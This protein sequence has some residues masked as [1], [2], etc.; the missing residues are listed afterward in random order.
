[1][2]QNLSRDIPE[3][4]KIYCV[5]FLIAKIK[6]IQVPDGLCQPNP[7]FMQL[8][9]FILNTLEE[10]E[11]T[12]KKYHCQLQG[13]NKCFLRKSAKTFNSQKRFAVRS[14]GRWGGVSKFKKSTIKRMPKFR[15]RRKKVSFYIPTRRFHCSTYLRTFKFPFFC[16]ALNE[17]SSHGTQFLDLAPGFSFSCLI[18]ITAVM[19]Q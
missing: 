6:I 3:L 1:M 5:D 17:R 15:K 2:L 16:F 8:N 11:L 14:L 7:I 13:L 10:I 9:R 18:F 4:L 12:L 19:S